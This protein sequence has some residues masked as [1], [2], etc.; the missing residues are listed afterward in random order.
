MRSFEDGVSM[1]LSLRSVWQMSSRLVLAAM[2]TVGFGAC[3]AKVDDAAGQAEE[4]KD[5]R[6]R[7]EAIKNLASIHRRALNK[8]GGDRTKPEVKAVT[9]IIFDEVVEVYTAHPE[10]SKAGQRLLELVYDMRD[11]RT[12][13]AL[14][15]A[16]EWRRDLTE[17]HAILSAKTIAAIE[18][19]ANER[20]TVAKKLGEALGNVVNARPVDN[21]MRIEFLRALG[22]IED[23]ESAAALV[24]IAASEAPEQN[25]LINRLAAEQLAFVAGPESVEPMVRGL[26]MFSP[27]NPAMRMNDLASQ[28]LVHVGRPALEPLIATLRGQNAEANAIVDR[29]IAAVREKDAASAASMNARTIVSNEAAFALGQLGLREAIPALLE[30]TRVA[31]GANDAEEAAWQNRRM[32]A[33]IA[34][35]SINRLDSDTATVR[36]ALVATYNNVEK[37]PRMQVLAA[38]QHAMDAGL[39][40]FLLG[41]AKRPDDELPDIRIVAFKAYVMLANKSEVVAA[42]ALIN[43]EP[44]DDDGGLK[45]AFSPLAPVLV[46][47]TECDADVACWLAKLEDNNVLLGRKAAYMLARLGRGRADVVAALVKKLDHPLE[48]VRGDILYALDF[49][50]TSGSAEAVAKI[51]TIRKNEEGRAIWNHTKDLALAVSARMSGRLAAQ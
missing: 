25:F 50:A 40:P 42:Q 5:G 19:P 27:T 8:A 7:P 48:E 44:G 26:Y 18:I 4:L 29:Y 11:P 45:S 22:T 9:D 10:E 35:V 20:S 33:A 38:M 14:L 37:M 36:D 12:L 21:R 47:A 41:E 31:K 46:A 13:P 17:E 1:I 24:K 30:E 23:P 49:V 15:K 16:L 43:S 51:E 6:Y 34:L 39:L 2:L 32:G 28:I 3:R